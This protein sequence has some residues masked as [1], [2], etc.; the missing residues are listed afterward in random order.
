MIRALEKEICRCSRLSSPRG[1]RRAA[2]P[3]HQASASG[4]SKHPEILV[5]IPEIRNCDARKGDI[6]LDLIK[7]RT[8]VV[9]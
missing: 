9:A 2:S 6:P 3:H 5:E 7:K 1:T 4:A 8:I